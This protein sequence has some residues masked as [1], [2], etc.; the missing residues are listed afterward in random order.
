MHQ[1][2]IFDS[3]SYVS[4]V[5]ALHMQC[6]TPLLLGKK[7]CDCTNA[8]NYLCLQQ[9]HALLSVCAGPHTLGSPRFSQFIGV[10]EIPYK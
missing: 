6:C 10:D 5:K 7:K 2:Y 4:K 9:C 3:E 8:V 1:E